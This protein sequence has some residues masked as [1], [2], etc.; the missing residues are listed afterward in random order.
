MK[1]VQKASGVSLKHCFSNVMCAYITWDLVKTKKKWVLIQQT[2]A[3][4]KILY[5]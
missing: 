5:F 4:P 1:Q 3:E 2:W